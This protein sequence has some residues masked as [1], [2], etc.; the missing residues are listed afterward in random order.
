EPTVGLH[1]SDIKKLLSVLNNLVDTGNTV[2]LVEHNLD[3]IKS[4]D[5]IIDLGPEGGEEGGEIIAEGTPERIMEEKKSYTG[6]YLKKY[7]NSYVNR[8]DTSAPC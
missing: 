1:P 7:L 6:F 4:A 8:D 5:W 3:V 2:I